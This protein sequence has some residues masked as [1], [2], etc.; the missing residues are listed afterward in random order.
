M[1]HL[2][3]LPPTPLSK[4]LRPEQLS[5]LYHREHVKKHTH[6]IACAVACVRKCTEFETQ[7]YSRLLCFSVTCQRSCGILHCESRHTRRTPLSTAVCSWPF[8]T[9]FALTSLN[10]SGR[11]WSCKAMLTIL[12]CQPYAPHHH[13]GSCSGWS[14]KPYRWVKSQH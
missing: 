9:S 13:S 4:Y 5:R 3:N 11:A 8:R 12:I 2:I 10:S 7:H 1:Q 14:V 6:V